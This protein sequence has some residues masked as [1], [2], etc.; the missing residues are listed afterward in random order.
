MKNASSNSWEST[1][2]GFYIGAKSTLSTTAP[3]RA[4][5][6]V[7]P[8]FAGPA[9]DMEVIMNAITKD[10]QFTKNAKGQVQFDYQQ[11]YATLP[12]IFLRFGG[13]W[14]EVLPKDYVTYNLGLSNLCTVLMST[15]ADDTWMLGTAVMKGYHVNFDVG[16]DRVGIAPNNYS[17]KAQLTDDSTSSTT[18]TTTTTTTPNTTTTTTTTT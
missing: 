9:T 12:T 10:M 16:N 17:T 18:T 13:Y 15:T 5:L 4:I 11:Y 1:I 2:D 6:D 8:W 7:R 14:I 3:K